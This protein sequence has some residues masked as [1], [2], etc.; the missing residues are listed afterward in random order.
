MRRLFRS[1]A[2]GLGTTLHVWPSK[3]SI[4]VRAVPVVVVSPTVQTSLE[5]TAATPLS[6]VPD[7]AE[8]WASFHVWP[9]QRSITAAPKRCP[10]A[11]T[12]SVDAAATPLSTSKLFGPA[13]MVQTE[14]FQCSLSG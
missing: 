11:H 1:L 14:P 13:T 3:C 2:L 8:S 7:P 12:A 9:F 6:V 10:T 5:D 4:N